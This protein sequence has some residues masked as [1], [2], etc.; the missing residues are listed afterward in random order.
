MLAMNPLLMPPV[1]L[2]LLLE[3][4]VQG[5]LNLSGEASQIVL[6]ADEGSVNPVDIALPLRESCLLAQP[7]PEF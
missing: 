1:L 7:Y 4:V 5:L 6:S 3:K 2:A